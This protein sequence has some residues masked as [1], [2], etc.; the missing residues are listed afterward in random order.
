[1]LVVGGKGE[2]TSRRN[3]RP[4]ECAR[5]GAV[6]D[7]FHAGAAARNLGPSSRHDLADAVHVLHEG[8]EGG[9]RR[10]IHAVPVARDALTW[11]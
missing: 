2:P 8:K 5:P 3:R 4:V 1:M 11:E 9:G 6:V 10:S 7:A